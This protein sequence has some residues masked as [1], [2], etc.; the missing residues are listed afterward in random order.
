[1]ALRE[2]AVISA[3][4]QLLCQQKDASVENKRYKSAVSLFVKSLKSFIL[5]A[6]THAGSA[7]AW[8]GRV[9]AWATALLV[10]VALKPAGALGD[11]LAV[12][13]PLQASLLVK[14]A[15][16]ERNISDRQGEMLTILAVLKEGNSESRQAATQL[17]RALADEK[18]IAGR[19]HRFEEVTYQDSFSLAKEIQR[20]EAHIVYLTPGFS[21]SEIRAIA[22]AFASIPV[23]SVGALASYVP[24]GAVL[25]IDLVSGKPKLVVNLPQA[26]KQEVKFDAGLLKLARVI[27]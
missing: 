17:K 11:D 21:N 24:A 23:L 25:G 19:P 16:Y 5:A 1:M 15:S 18:M 6:M 26:K 3:P 8:K 10:A 12:P 7:A 14:V 9:A 22:Q 20:S 27:E 2:D 4:S 13:I